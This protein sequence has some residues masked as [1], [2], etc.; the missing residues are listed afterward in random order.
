VNNVP[1]AV[2]TGR[3]VAMVILGLAIALTVLGLIVVIGL[4]ASQPVTV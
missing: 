4:L 2:A 1:K 3:R